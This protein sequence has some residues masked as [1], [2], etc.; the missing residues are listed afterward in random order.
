MTWLSDAAMAHLCRVADWPDL[1][2]SRYELIDK[3]GQGGMGAVFQVQDRELDRPVAMKVLQTPTPDPEAAARILR[4][5]RVLARLE[6]PSIVPVHDC[7]VLADRRFYYTMKLVRGKRLDEWLSASTALAERLRLFLK[8][9]DAVE[10]AHAHGVLHR[11]LK[12]Q[13][14]MLGSFGEVLVMDWGVAKVMSERVPAAEDHSS[15]GA[16]LR[17]T[18][19]AHGTVLG[20][21]G[22]MAP[23]QAR[24]LVDE[25]DERA[26]VY[27]LGAILHFLLTGKRPNG[28]SPRSYN[29]SISRPLNA[30]CLKA[31]A[32]EPTARYASVTELAADVTDFLA[33]RRV[34]AY[35]E[36]PFRAT[37]RLTTRYRTAVA[38]ILTYLVVRLLF[39]LLNP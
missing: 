16:A 25:I 9:C 23:E 34:R 13:N 30:I 37:L 35:P 19:T 26:D 27:A 7:G 31:L 28:R 18:Q 24:G 15:S 8:M 29:R 10:F 6:H 33:G 14:I 39:F 22:Y 20:T 21:P 11:D 3:I 4:E 36:G 1:S 32:T 17:P 12:P 38:L 2:G 5:A